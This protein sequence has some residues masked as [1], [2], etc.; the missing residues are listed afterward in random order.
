MRSRKREDLNA[1][2]EEGALSCN[3]MH[4]ANISYRVGRTLHWDAK[5][6]TIIDD[7]E[8]NKMLTREYGRRSWC[9]RR[10]RIAVGGSRFAIRVAKTG[11]EW[12]LT[13]FSFW[14]RVDRCFSAG[15]GPRRRTSVAV[16][17]WPDSS[18][19]GDRHRRR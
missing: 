4:L 12:N 15:S 18:L 6:M 1:E 3:L 8:A 14:V 16:A 17:C 9:R 19:R 7:A 11:S 2:V 10:S 5:T 13:P